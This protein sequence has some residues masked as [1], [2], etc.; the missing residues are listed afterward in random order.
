ML[1]ALPE[2]GGRRGWERWRR[3]RGG[4]GEKWKGKWKET[5]GEGEEEGEG[6][7]EKGEETLILNIR[8][9]WILTSPLA[10][11]IELR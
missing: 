1:E 5:G 4:E 2:K 3:G 7:G 6:D 9:Q 11:Q 8:M 10:Y